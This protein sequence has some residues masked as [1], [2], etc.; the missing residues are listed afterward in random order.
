MSTINR[1]KLI[2]IALAVVG[3]GVV[4][5]TNNF[6]NRPV[7]AFSAGPPPGRTGG[8]GEDTCEECHLRVG[9]STG[10][11]TINAPQ[12]YLPGQTYLLTVQHSSSDPTRQRWGFELTALDSGNQK[13]GDLQ[14]G[15]DGLTQLRSN[16]DPHP[17]RQYIE[18][19]AAGTFAGQA[20]GASWSFQWTA[21]QQSV[22]PVTFYAAGNQANNNGNSDGDFIYSTFV[23]VNPA[24][25]Y[26][27]NVTPTARVIA[28]GGSTTYNLLVT[29]S[30]GFTGQVDLSLGVL[31]AGVSATINPSS[32]NLTNNTA[33]SATLTIN[34]T[35]GAPLG[36]LNLI[37]S[38]SSG[39]LARSAQATLTI[40]SPTSADLAITN[41][42]SPD[43][44]TTGSNLTY[45]VVVTNNGPASAT[46]VNVTDALPTNVNFVSAAPTQGTCSG[47][48]TITCALGSLALN[49]SA[50]VNI[51]VAPQATGT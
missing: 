47:T 32:V 36:T 15:G 4:L 44:A 41:S 24:T 20:N 19:T 17:D 37:P 29:P 49:S 10:T 11:L 33:Q 1:V 27:L 5:C 34:T 13:A 18:H 6:I 22:G 9:T 28:P 43:P 35:S 2:I 46:N 7:A 26:T 16:E 12:T 30:G 21:P 8:P 25:D 42:D 45:R 38:A 50:T 51:V 39:V 14:T 48:Q 23:T 3:C 31:P 40:A